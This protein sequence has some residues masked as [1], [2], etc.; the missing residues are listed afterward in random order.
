MFAKYKSCFFLNPQNLQSFTQNL[1]SR[2]NSAISAE[3]KEKEQVSRNSSVDLV[4]A[5]ASSSV[6]SSREDSLTEIS[7]TAYNQRKFESEREYKVIYRYVQTKDSRIFIFYAIRPR[8]T[9]I[10]Y[11]NCAV[12]HNFQICFCWIVFLPITSTSVKFCYTTTRSLCYQQTNC[13]F[14]LSPQKVFE[15]ILVV[16]YQTILREHAPTHSFHI[17]IYQ[18]LI[19]FDINFIIIRTFPLILPLKYSITF[20]SYKNVFTY[21]YGHGNYA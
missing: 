15:H 19:V 17:E 16:N 6:N 9:N 21:I 10:Y 5:D 11:R 2:K 1:E 8:I 14:L 3:F 7:L 4:K 18:T 20:K 13:I 12:F